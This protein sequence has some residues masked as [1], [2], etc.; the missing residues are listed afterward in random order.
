V[1]PVAR[2]PADDPVPDVVFEIRR[3]RR[4]APE[5]ARS[6]PSPPPRVI[7][8]AVRRPVASAMPRPIVEAADIPTRA[9]ARE[10]QSP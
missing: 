8:A 9:L 5:G 1:A 2:R 3:I 7:A 10:S 6:S 4:R